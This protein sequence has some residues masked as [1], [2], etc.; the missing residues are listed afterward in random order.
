M[1]FFCPDVTSPVPDPRPPPAAEPP[2]ALEA[3]GSS[4]MTGALDGRLASGLLGNMS[5]LESGPPSS[6]DEPVRGPAGS[7][8]HP[9]AFL[10]ATMAPPFLART[11][12]EMFTLVVPNIPRADRKELASDVDDTL[13]LVF[14]LTLALV[15]PAANRACSVLYP[16]VHSARLTRPRPSRSRAP[17]ASVAPTA[18][19]HLPNRDRRNSA[20]P[21]EP[22]WS[23]SISSKAARADST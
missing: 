16:A 7:L 8:R 14:M 13:P 19:S 15:P 12:C 18:P 4:V 2:A 10:L 3:S 1:Y 21:T 5:S 20:G 17:K 22:S 23:E 9:F 6:C 11:S